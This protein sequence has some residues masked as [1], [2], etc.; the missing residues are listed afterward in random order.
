[1]REAERVKNWVAVYRQSPLKYNC[2]AL[3]SVLRTDG[4]RMLKLVLK[5]LGLELSVDLVKDAD[6]NS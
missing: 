1:M 5:E 2:N 6:K 3:I 4:E